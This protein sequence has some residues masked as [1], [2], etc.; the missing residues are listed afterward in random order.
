MLAWCLAWCCILW[1]PW[2]GSSRW[3]FSSPAVHL[4]LMA[5]TAWRWLNIFSSSCGLYLWVGQS[6]FLQGGWLF[7][8]HAFQKIPMEATKHAIIQP[9]KKFST[10]FTVSYWSKSSQRLSIN[11]RE[12]AVHECKCKCSCFIRGSSLKTTDIPTYTTGLAQKVKE[13]R[14]HFRKGSEAPGLQKEFVSN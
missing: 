12:G 10:T 6:D 3:L 5:E 14:Y 1:L 7:P 11:I 9:W 2:L 8:E 13:R 4:R